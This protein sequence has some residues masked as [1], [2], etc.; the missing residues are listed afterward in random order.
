MY[1]EELVQL[2]CFFL[3]IYSFDFLL[4]NLAV[5]GVAFYAF[6]GVSEFNKKICIC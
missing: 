4:P 1:L 5:N 3:P 2:V 6:I